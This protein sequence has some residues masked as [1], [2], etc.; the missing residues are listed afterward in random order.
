MSEGGPTYLSYLLRLWRVS[1]ED[2]P[3]WRASLQSAET[4]ERVGFAGLDELFDYLRQ[5]AGVETDQKHKKGGVKMWVHLTTLKIDPDKVEELKDLL[6]DDEFCKSCNERGGLYGQLWQAD[7]PGTFL[8]LTV[9]QIRAKG[10][11]FFKTQ[12]YAEIVGRIKPLLKG[13]PSAAS[14]EVIAENRPKT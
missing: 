2:R 12:E 5:Q 1:D 3:V 10:E 11:A 6:Y 9:W 14:Y 4:G 7:E 13:M 8:S